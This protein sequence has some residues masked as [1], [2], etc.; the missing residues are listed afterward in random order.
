MGG[1]GRGGRKEKGGGDG[2][3]GRK[4][5]Q[6]ADRKPGLHS[7]ITPRLG[8][9][10]NIFYATRRLR[11]VDSEA[12]GFRLGNYFGRDSEPTQPRLGNYPSV[13]RKLKD[14]K[15]IRHASETITAHR[16][17]NFA[18]WRLGNFPTATPKL[19]PRLENY[20]LDAE[21]MVAT[22][23]L[24]SRVGNTATIWKLHT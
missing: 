18:R 17:G 15:H 10:G 1:E 23:K 7:E 19:R 5:E 24:W 3:R 16:I 20:R 11:F 6:K 12:T 13:S 8:N 2:I 9:Y 22:R 14:L 21:N 4:G